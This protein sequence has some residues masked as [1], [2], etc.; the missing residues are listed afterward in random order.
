MS[1]PTITNEDARDLEHE[2]LIERL[3]EQLAIYDQPSQPETQAE[4]LERLSLTIEEMPEIYR[5]L[6]Q[7]WSWGDHW[8]DSLKDMFGGGDRRYKAMRQRRDLF[9][10]MASSAKMR[11]ESAS[12]QI[13]LLTAFDETG[14]PRTRRS[15]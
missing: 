8:A 6:Q 1:R 14:M 5:W 4:R 7:L 13:T 11:Y 9:E 15:G 2:A 12:R 10:K 3:E